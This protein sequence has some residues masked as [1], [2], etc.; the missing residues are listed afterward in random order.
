M[1]TMTEDNTIPDIQ[2]LRDAVDRAM[3]NLNS[4]FVEGSG[5]EIEYVD[6]ARDI[7]AEVST[8][9]YRSSD[10]EDED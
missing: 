10:D 3:K 8:V 9:G 1:N 6:A 4:F 2:A 5:E 7:L